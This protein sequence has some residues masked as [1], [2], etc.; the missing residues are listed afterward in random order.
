MVLVELLPPALDRPNILAVMAAIKE[1]QSPTT[2]VLAAALPLTMLGMGPTAVLVA[3]DLVLAVLAV[4]ALAE[5]ALTAVPQPIV[6]A[7]LVA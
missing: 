5:L 2:V 1:P 7:V 4:V 3:T 6:Q